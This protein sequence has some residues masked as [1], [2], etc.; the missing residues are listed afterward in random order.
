MGIP[1]FLGHVREIGRQV[2]VRGTHLGSKRAREV[3]GEILGLIPKVGFAGF[4]VHTHQESL[5]CL[6]DLIN[7]GHESVFRTGELIHPCEPCLHRACD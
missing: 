4:S 7:A 2:T 3:S 6:G 5:S 1:D